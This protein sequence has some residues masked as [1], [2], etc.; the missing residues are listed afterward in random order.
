MRILS[1]NINGV[2]TL[3][4]YHPWNTFTSFQGILEHLKADIIC[5]QEMKTSRS[6]LSRCVA[7]PE[8]FEAFFSF[9]QNKGGYSG[10]AVYANSRTVIPLRAEEGLSGILQPKPP[11]TSDDRISCSYPCTHEIELMPDEHG[12]TPSDFAA[13]DAEGRALIVD[14]GLFV[15]INVYCPN[16]TSD[17]RLPFKINFHV[18]LQD[19]VQKLMNEGREV[20]VVGDINV[21]ATPLDHCDGHLASNT[22]TFYDHPARAWFHRWLSPIGCMTDAVRT[23]WPGRKA[24]YTCWNTKISAR[25]TNYGTRVDYIL[26]T[27]GMLPWI[28]HG[29]IQPSLKGSDHCPIYIDLH[30]E[31]TTDAGERLFL[32]D[33]LPIN[34]NREDLPRL[35]ARRWEEYSGK[36]KLLSMFFE[37]GNKLHPPS[38]SPLSSLSPTP[39]TQLPRDHSGTAQ[40]DHTQSAIVIPPSNPSLSSRNSACASTSQPPEPSLQSNPSP[41]RQTTL[42]ASSTK[43]KPSDNAAKKAPKK[44]KGGQSKLSSFFAQPTVSH[45][46]S[47]EI[48]PSDVTDYQD[49]IDSDHQLALELA[50]SLEN[51]LSQGLATSA[52]PSASQSKAAWS[53]L[54]API[55]PPNCLVH[56]E[57]AKEH[58]VNKPGLNKGKT[59]F[60]CS[61]SVGP[62]YD[63]GKSERL[64]EE[65]D[66]RYRCN[67]FKWGNDAR[68]EAKDKFSAS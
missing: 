12:S 48:S 60:L 14:F 4:Q 61:R 55:Q 36:Q 7:L 38:N 52:T 47:Q 35:A 67:F 34:G 2:R 8:D 50:A 51:P 33:V 32:R 49:Y 21:C 13:L 46:C 16:E 22:A 28:K 30:D 44:L 64:R 53:Q 17:A 3:P 68:R 57:P 11:L 58:T 41:S 29:D 19:R 40:P 5:F 45:P 18:M 31:I 43:R 25:E 65:V 10:V 54:M 9:P 1:W 27:P 42:P 26:V 66:H 23:F 62:G 20:V 59:F 15:L 6:S 63:K 39:D 56:G 24:M 37:K